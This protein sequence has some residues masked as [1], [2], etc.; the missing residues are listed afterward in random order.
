MDGKEADASL[1]HAQSPFFWAL[2]TAARHF[3]SCLET[4]L[5]F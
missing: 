5:V 2:E 4:L 3:S 1:P